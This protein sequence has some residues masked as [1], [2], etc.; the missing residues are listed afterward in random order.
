MLPTAI[1]S[2]S[3]A[4]TRHPTCLVIFRPFSV[5]RGPHL[6]GRLWKTMPL[7]LVRRFL[8]G[9]VKGAGRGWPDPA[10]DPAKTRCMPDD[11]ED[12][13]PMFL[14]CVGLADFC[15]NCFSRTRRAA[16]QACKPAQPALPRTAPAG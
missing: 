15:F 12:V 1:A 8:P 6:R 3:A 4:P 2:A 11:P 9:G 10:P 5:W 7:H 13:A 16:G 14:P